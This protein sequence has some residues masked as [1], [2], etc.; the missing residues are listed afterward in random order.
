M[1]VASTHRQR[2]LEELR[3][4]SR[5]LDDDLLSVR[6]GITPRQTVNQ[7]CRRLAS[8]GLVRRETGP[9]GKLVNA[10]VAN[11]CSDSPSPRSVS[12]QPSVIEPQAL[13]A[14]SSSEQRAAERHMLDALG[15][16]LGVRL[17]PRSLSHTSGARVELDGA[18]TELSVL[19]ECWA[20]QGTAKVAQKYKLMNDA[21]KLHWIATTLPH[22][23]RLILCLSDDAAGRHLSGRSWQ[24]QALRDLGVTVEVVALPGDVRDWIVAAQK[25]QYR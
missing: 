18:D 7:V 23:P 14:G 13:P 12:V 10:L 17:D 4:S 16:R 20:H 21:V 9:D 25:R 15:S 24:G 1:D 5:P 22:R 11:A 19:V 8:E 6:T 2:I 3:I